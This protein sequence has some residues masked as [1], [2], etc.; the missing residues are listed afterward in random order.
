M[1]FKDLAFYFITETLGN[2][3]FHVLATSIY[4][5]FYTVPGATGYLVSIISDDKRDVR[6]VQA[7]TSLFSV[8]NLTARTNYQIGVDATVNGVRTAVGALAQVTT[9]ERKLQLHTQQNFYT[10]GH[11]VALLTTW[12]PP[13]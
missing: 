4:I 13:H 8:S 6:V 7:N 2:V 9:A 3:N 5:Q 1:S 12:C 10:G 11:D